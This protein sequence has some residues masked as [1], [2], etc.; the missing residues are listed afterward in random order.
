MAPDAPSEGKEGGSGFSGLTGHPPSGPAGL[1]TSRAAC[2]R[3]YDVCTGRTRCIRHKSAPGAGVSPQ[4]GG[5]G[6]NGWPQRRKVIL[7]QS[8]KP[9]PGEI[10]LAGTGEAL[11]CCESSTGT[12]QPLWHGAREGG[13]SMKIPGGEGQL[14]AASPSPLSPLSLQPPLR[15][16]PQGFSWLCTRTTGSASP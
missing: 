13:C 15:D 10:L 7:Q 16:R 9:S 11:P 4:A 1:K 14:L 5:V 8:R 6:Q 2:K 3:L 12:A